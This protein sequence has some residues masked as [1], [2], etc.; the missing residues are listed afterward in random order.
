MTEIYIITGPDKMQYVGQ[1]VQVVASGRS[2]GALGRFKQHLAR[3]KGGYRDSSYLYNAMRKHGPDSFTMEVLSVCK[4]EQAN[5]EEVA[6]IKQHNTFYP[7]GYNLTRGGSDDTP[8]RAAAKAARAS[9]D[10]WKQK[11]SVANKGRQLTEEQLQRMKAAI[12]GRT[13]SVQQREKNSRAHIARVIV[14]KDDLPRNITK[15]RGGYAVRV[16]RRLQKVH[17]RRWFAS[18]KLTDEQKLAAAKAFLDETLAMLA[19]PCDQPT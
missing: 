6:A 14:R 18:S 2:K 4:K 16:E 19:S 10:E 1:S 15:V 12:K 5:D 8:R 11:I 3:A 7:H 17:V 9:N 13:I